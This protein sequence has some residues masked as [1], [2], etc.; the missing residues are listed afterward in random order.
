M[1]PLALIH[2]FPLDA[3]MWDEQVAALAGDTRVLAPSLPGFGG[4][5]SAGDVLTMERM[6]DHVVAEL[7]RQEVERA[8][9][10]GLSMGGYAALELWRRHRDRVAALILADTRAEPDDDAGREKRR[11]LAEKVRAEG[12]GA[13][14][15]APPP[16]L[17]EGAEPD[18][19]EAVKA[20]IRR[21]P[22]EAI[23]A[24]A[25]GMAERPDSG[26]TLATIDVP[27]LVIVGSEDT[28][29]PPPL[30]ERLARE[31]PG[32]QLVTLEGAGHLS[33]L[34]DPD[35]FTKAVRGFLERVG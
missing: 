5:P 6:A 3:S 21:Q 17:A 30:S 12:S 27:T 4:V 10:G 11:A 8:V 26:P 32:A 22:A 34:E 24:A 15:D 28:L 2:A 16:L 19:W 31:I 20:T 9:I 18:L 29:T 33:N 25:L 23:A 13:V 35:G 1:K 7:D 14:A